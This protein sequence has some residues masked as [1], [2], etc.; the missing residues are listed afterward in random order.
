[1]KQ[2]QNLFTRK[3]PMIKGEKRSKAMHKVMP[4]YKINRKLQSL[5]RIRHK[6]KEVSHSDKLQK[7][8]W[9]TETF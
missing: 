5:Q 3:R 7:H 8:M 6:E 4:D 9:V 2:L 1:M